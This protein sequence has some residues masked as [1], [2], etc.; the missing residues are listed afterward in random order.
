MVVNFFTAFSGLWVISLVGLLGSSP[1]NPVL[2]AL[3]CPSW[4][5]S[6]HPVVPVGVPGSGSS[7]HFPDHQPAFLIRCL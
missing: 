5:V 6:T 1:V 3:D 4:S 7:M 2:T